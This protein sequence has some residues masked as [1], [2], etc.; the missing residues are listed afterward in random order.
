M[1]GQK[2]MMEHTKHQRFTFPREGRGEKGKEVEKGSGIVTRFGGV[3][4]VIVVD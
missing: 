3:V 4:K 1:L 2:Y